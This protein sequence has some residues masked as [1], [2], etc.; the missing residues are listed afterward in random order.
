MGLRP[1]RRADQGSIR[2]PTAPTS[3]SIDERSDRDGSSAGDAV[4]GVG[5]SSEAL[6]LIVEAKVA[7]LLDGVDALTAASLEPSGI[8]VHDGA[9]YVIFDNVSVIARIEDLSARS[10]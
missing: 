8:C 5:R 6:E 9:F 7:D 3:I 10:P 1:R 2:T 4:T